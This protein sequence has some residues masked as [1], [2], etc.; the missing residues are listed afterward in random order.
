[1]TNS[2][3]RKYVYLAGVR[4]R[5]NKLLPRY[6]FLLESQSWGRE[7]LQNYQLA[8]LKE[9]LVHARDKCEYYRRVFDDSSFDPTAIR[10]LSDIRN[11]P[12]L[13]KDDLLKNAGAIQIR[14]YPE[15]LFYS[16]TSGSTGRP[17]VFYRNQ[18]W[19]AWHRASVFRGYSWYGVEPWERNGYL[20]GYNFSPLKQLR[21]KLLDSLQNRFRLFSYRD[22]EIGKFL[23]K[24][25]AASFVGGYSS[26]I[27]EVAKKVNARGV[28]ADLK[29]K[30]VK[31][32]SEKIL[33]SYQQ[34]SLL[35][36][37]RKIT[38]EYGAAEAGIIAFECPHG[39]MHI[40]META[41]VEEID[42]E[43]IVTNLVSKSFPIIRYKL[44]D[45]VDV[46]WNT[47]CPC[48]MA[49]PIIKDVLGR[50][51]KVIYG[52]SET[53]PSLTLYYVFKNLAMSHNLV[54]NYQAIQKKRGE[55]ELAIENDV[56]AGHRVLLEREFEKY[57]ADDIDVTIRGNMDLKSSAKKKA[58]FV[59]EI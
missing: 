47:H 45:Y 11:V 18:D 35:A 55:L 58:D 54:F 38:S 44:G 19:D 23:E 4:V 7:A 52:V 33:D 59:S 32:T 30:M 25:K 3:F 15:K 22:E 50:V 31:G 57:F 48:G 28:G 26:M 2:F 56:S 49:H 5:N 17:L 10:T 27:Y 16:E 34:A 20:W 39:H 12:V 14:P 42:N 41:I 1:M 40:N 51:G 21:T 46:D 43:I 53:Y 36:F 9:L 8:R 6:K 29:L 13:T 37:G 24:L